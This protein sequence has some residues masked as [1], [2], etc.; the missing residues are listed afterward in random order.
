MFTMHRIFWYKKNLV[1]LIKKFPYILLRKPDELSAKGKIRCMWK[2][3][4]GRTKKCLK[5]ICMFGQILEVVNPWIFQHSCVLACI[6]TPLYNEKFQQK[7]SRLPFK[8][9]FSR[10]TM[11]QGRALQT[12]S[13]VMEILGCTYI[14]IPSWCYSYSLKERISHY[15][16]VLG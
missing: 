1:I 10:E 13:G 11:V 6:Y 8:I 16:Y 2:K 14:K 3:V 9:S 4:L 5:E 7:Y 15:N 12:F